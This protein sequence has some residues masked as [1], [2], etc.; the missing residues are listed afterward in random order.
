MDD[1]TERPSPLAKLSPVR[2]AAVAALA[3]VA[4]LVVL[5]IVRQFAPDAPAPIATLAGAVFFFLG[6]QLAFRR[7]PKPVPAGDDDA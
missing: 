1:E 5:M 3:I 7:E 6:F 4:G 2:L